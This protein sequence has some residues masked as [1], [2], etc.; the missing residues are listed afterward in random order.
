MMIGC[1]R[2]I[3]D[4]FNR[5]PIVR[6]GVTATPLR[7]A[8]QGNQEFLVDMACFPGSSG[9]PVFVFDRGSFIDRTGYHAGSSRLF[10]VGVLYSGPTVTNS[11][12]II[13]NQQPSVNVSTMMH[14]GQVIKSTEVLDIE[15]QVRDQL[16]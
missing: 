11:G 4:E 14:L 15:R 5:I 8:Y 7:M 3:Y 13:L 9:S 10:F 2:G 6:R 12:E 16:A 1:P